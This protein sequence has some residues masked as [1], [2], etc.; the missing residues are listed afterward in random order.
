MKITETASLS[1]GAQDLIQSEILEIYKHL[2][3]VSHLVLCGELNEVWFSFF[4]CKKALSSH[5]H[6]FLLWLLVKSFTIRL[7]FERIIDLQVPVGGLSCF[8]LI[9]RKTSLPFMWLSWTPFLLTVSAEENKTK[10]ANHGA[11]TV[12]WVLPGG[13]FRIRKNEP[14]SRKQ[15]TQ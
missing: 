6:L 8:S 13:T 10:T 11:V 7:D 14:L 2:I 9:E 5:C 12:K 1:L 3:T 4:W 15:P